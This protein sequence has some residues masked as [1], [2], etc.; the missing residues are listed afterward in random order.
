MFDLISDITAMKARKTRR[1]I[2]ANTT[3][4]KVIEIYKARKE[5]SQNF[6]KSL[7]K[8]QSMNK[9]LTESYRK[10]LFKSPMKT[11]NNLS[12]IVIE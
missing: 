4:I 2:T 1:M 8:F 10:S 6:K 11:Y 7:A 5:T 12:S 3:K 9:S